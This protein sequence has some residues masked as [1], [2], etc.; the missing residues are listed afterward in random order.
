MNTNKLR[1]FINI[2]HVGDILAIDK[3]CYLCCTE[4]GP[5]INIA[6]P[7]INSTMY[8]YCFN[9]FRRGLRLYG[10]S[11]FLGFLTL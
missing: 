5:S 10:L 2:W 6:G 11:E 7:C 9:E 1:Y 3:F 4:S 8:G